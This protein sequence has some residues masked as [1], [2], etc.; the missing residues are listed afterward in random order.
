MKY[1]LLLTILAAGTLHGETPAQ[2]AALQAQVAALQQEVAALQHNPALALGPFVTVNVNPVNDIVAPTIVFHG[3]NIQLVNGMGQTGLTNGLGNLILGYGEEAK[4]GVG[5]QWQYSG[6]GDRMGSHNMMLGVYNKYKSA[7]VAS[8]VGGTENEVNAGSCFVF[9]GQRNEAL[10]G[11]TTIIAGEMN[12]T[13]TTATIL[14]SDGNLELYGN[15][16][17]W[18]QA[19]FQ[20]RATFTQS[21]IFNYPID[22]TNTAP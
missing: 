9:A 21:T 15:M 4:L 3:V 10:A 13:S 5:T 6:P 20:S 8:I 19:T 17:V 14:G 22:V 12:S 16:L 2:F 11:G 1:A 7:A 18:A